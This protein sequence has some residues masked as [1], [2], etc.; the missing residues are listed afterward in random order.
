MSYKYN[1]F[2]NRLDYYESGGSIP[3]SVLEQVTADAGTAIPSS[4]NLNIV[5]GSGISTSASGDTVT[6]TNTG[7]AGGGL[8]SLKNIPEWFDDFIWGTSGSPGELGWIQLGGSTSNLGSTD[9]H[10][11][12]VLVD[13]S[14]DGPAGYNAL[15]SNQSCSLASGIYTFECVVILPVVDT[16]PDNYE[17]HIGFIDAPGIPLANE[18]CFVY[19]NT[20]NAGNWTGRVTVAGVSTDLDLGV[21]VTTDWVNL[22]IVISPGSV[23][24]YIQGVLEGNIATALPTAYL[25]WMFYIQKLLDTNGQT[26]YIGIDAFYGKIELTNQR[27]F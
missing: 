1:P 15:S 2:T 18:V 24:F 27:F 26:E 14:I 5:G 17:A 16:V 19:N 12:S 25:Y 3:G 4:N 8:S 10:P 13:V 7:G 6:I 22:K 9:D 23:D 21:A 11:G 20:L